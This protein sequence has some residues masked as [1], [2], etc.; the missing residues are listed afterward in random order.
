MNNIDDLMLELELEDG[1]HIKVQVTGYHLKLADKLNFDGG[2]KLFKLG[3][4]KINSRQY[5]EWKGIAKIKYRIGECSVLKDQPPKETP[6][7]ITFKVRHD[8]N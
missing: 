5:P 4:F 6:R 8:F 7:T 3:T 1:R 2:G